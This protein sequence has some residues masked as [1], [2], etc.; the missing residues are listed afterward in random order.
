MSIDN[1]YQEISKQPR[2]WLVTGAAGFIG[3]NLVKKL[4][5]LR[6]NVTGLDNFSTG[7]RSNIAELTNFSNSAE[8]RFE[9]IQGDI[10]NPEDCLKATEKNEIVLHQAA[11]G[12]VPRS[13]DDPLNSHNSNVNGFINML[14]AVK[15]NNCEKFVF[16][17]SS[18][19]YGDAEELPK[20]ESRIGRPLSPYAA[21]K[22]VDEVYADVFAK[23]YGIKTIGL[24]YFNVFG[25]H[26]QPTGPY[27]AVI[28]KWIGLM[29]DNQAITIYG[30]GETSRDF[31]FI[32]NVVQ[33][34]LRAGMAEDDA[35]VNQVYNVAFNQRTT[36]NALFALIKEILITEVSD[37]ET[38][39]P[40][41]QNFRPGDVRHSLADI[42]KAKSLLGYQ[43]TDDIRGGLKKSIRWYVKNHRGK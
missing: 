21:T 7:L 19:V 14:W 23:T 13:I 38:F 11:L 5:Q 33:V 29:L 12:S 26:Q 43:P 37:L 20:V 16:A 41:F 36:L 22:V 42:S 8:C 40:V 27:A 6:Q 15:Q 39:P 35:A 4:L 28:P 1:F 34:N 3:T 10:C 24:R 30:D 17:S 18:S 25:P 31:C 9:F 32:D 2:N